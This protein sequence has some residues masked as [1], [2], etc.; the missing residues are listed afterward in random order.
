MSNSPSNENENSK[1]PVQTGRNLALA[2]AFLG[3]MFD[4]MEMGIFPLVAGPGLREMGTQH[5]IAIGSEELRQFVSFWMGWVTA[6]FLFGA[7]L[8]G[9]VF[10]WLGDR[11]GRVRAMSWSILCYSAFTGLCYFATE[12]WHMA[13]LRFVAAL[14]MGGEW[15]LGVAL[16]ME[17]WPGKWRSLLAGL[18]GAAANL[19]YV[20]IALIGIYIPIRDDL[21]DG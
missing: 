11:V 8:G 21:G 13:S 17:S 7:A 12:P 10:G 20:L 2:T 3:W 5:G 18:I 9:V 1:L 15:A 16:V 19:G 14:G 6:F 4:G